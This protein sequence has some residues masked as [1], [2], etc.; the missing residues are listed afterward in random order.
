MSS[1]WD[2]NLIFAMAQYCVRW[3]K[4]KLQNKFKVPTS[5]PY[6]VPTPKEYPGEKPKA[7][8]PSRLTSWLPGELKAL[9]GTLLA[10]LPKSCPAPRATPVAPRAAPNIPLPV[11]AEKPSRTTPASA[12][13]PTVA[14]ITTAAVPAG[15]NPMRN[16]QTKQNNKNIEYV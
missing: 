16:V 10:P 4:F 13:A 3:N 7:F 2:V 8:P 6:K 11:K 9:V 5:Y 15:V 1:S 14:P 12:A